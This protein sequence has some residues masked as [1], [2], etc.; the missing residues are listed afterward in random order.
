MEATQ[1]ET[2]LS[3]EPAPTS[4][5]TQET[6]PPVS[7]LRILVSIVACVILAGAAAGAITYIYAN[8]P[9]AQ[10]ES[11][12]RKTAAL[13]ET[14]ELTSGDYRPRLVVLGTVEPAREVMLSPRV[15]GQ[16]V[17]MQD[18]FAPGGIVEAGQPLVKLDAVD[19]E[20]VL[21][22][23]KS[24]L[25]Q[26]EALLSIEEG[27]QA[28][29]QSEFDLL[30]Q[31]IEAADRSL[32][33][34]EP[35]IKSIRAQVEAAR[36]AV[37][38]AELDVERTTVAAPFASQIMSRQVNLGSQV[39]PGAMLGTLVGIDEYWIMATVPLRDLRWLDF[40]E[41]S[42]AGSPA[43]VRLASAWPAGVSREGSVTR[44]MGTVDEQSRLAR[45]LVTVP[46]PLARDIEAPPLIL[47][48]IVEVTIEGRELADV[49]RIDRE[50]L[51]QNDT[52]WIMTDG[53]LDI[54]EVE[55]VYR[56]TFHAFIE[57]G[58]EPGEQMVTTSLA[59]IAPGLDLR[60]AEPSE[61]VDAPA[62]PASEDE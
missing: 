35:Q 59:T 7:F 46:D 6:P 27:R 48:T 47:G 60:K 25:E 57:T 55:V 21:A 24:E 22:T 12:T 16:I 53:K 32:V 30:G 11:A 41:A 54:R 42:H 31:D 29:A 10:R 58:L 2:P 19:Y 44:L 14:V 40:T 50:H 18:A 23:R 33:L 39:S 43:D 36:T 51:R 20:Q 28:V 5:S 62:T 56:D 37:R 8:E 13:V 45:V 9:E 17:E 3:D 34:R 26:V 52:V 38:Q 49:V 15:G 61:P 1:A 4:Q